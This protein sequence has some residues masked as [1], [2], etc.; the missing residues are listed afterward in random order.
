VVVFSSITYY[1]E[2]N[3]EESMFTSIPA[4]CWWCVVT[5]L[6]VGY[7]DM[8]PTS[9]AGK[10]IATVLMFFSVLVMALPIT[11]I[12]SS[13]S[14]SWVREPFLSSLSS[15]AD[16]TRSVPSPSLPSRALRTPLVVVGSVGA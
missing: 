1:A 16:S 2:K 7:G 15:A 8:A 11:I 9:V 13:F 6:T 5:V 12:G 3:E 14:N 4:T 10:L